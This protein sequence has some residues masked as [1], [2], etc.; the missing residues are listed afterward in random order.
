MLFSHFIVVVMTTKWERRTI[1]L[2]YLLIT[3]IFA[4]IFKAPTRRSLSN[5]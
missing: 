1:Q 4:A 2:N 5:R 3:A